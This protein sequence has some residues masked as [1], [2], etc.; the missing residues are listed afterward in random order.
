MATEVSF[1]F[2]KTADLFSASVDMNPLSFS[3]GVA[4]LSLAEGVEHSLQW[5]VKGMPGSDYSI[6]ISSPDAAKFKHSATLG[7]SLKDAGVHWF[8][9]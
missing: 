6:E 1:V 4:R 8:H 7:A 9:V 3:G 5:F 2:S